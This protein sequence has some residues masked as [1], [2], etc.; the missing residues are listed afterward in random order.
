MHNRAQRIEASV[1]SDNEAILAAN[2]E[3][4]AC[5]N[6][7]EGDAMDAAWSQREDVSCIHPGWNVL[8]GREAVVDSWRAILANPNQPR[9]VV[10]GAEVTLAG[11]CGVVIC[12]ELVAGSPLAATNVFVREDGGWKLLHHQSGPVSNIA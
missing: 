2:E 11:D 10:G 7:K 4:Y 5:F 8:L 1:E 3:F 12:R 6:R 9:I